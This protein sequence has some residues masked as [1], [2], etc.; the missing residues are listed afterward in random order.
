MVVAV[1][2][3]GFLA[4]FDWNFEEIEGVMKRQRPIRWEIY[5]SGP[6]L[7]WQWAIALVLGVTMLIQVFDVFLCLF[8]R[9]AK[10][11]WLSLG[12][13]LVAANGAEKMAS[14]GHEQG[15]GF[16]TERG[17]SVRYYV[18]RAAVGG[19]QDARAT[20]ISEDELADDDADVKY[21]RLDVNRSY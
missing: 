7:Q 18:R 1:L 5:G 4:T 15:A 12:G 10:G 21:P 9:Q 8:Y 19:T 11:L 16:V 3:S 13:M 2:F 6:R 14:A 17:K 20:L